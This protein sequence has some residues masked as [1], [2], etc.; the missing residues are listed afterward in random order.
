MSYTFNLEISGLFLI[1]SGLGCSFPLP[2]IPGHGVNQEA[3][4]EGSA[5]LHTCAS[6]SSL[7][8]SSLI[9]SR[10]SGS[11]IPRNT[12]I[13]FLV[14]WLKGMRCHNFYICRMLVMAPGR[15][16]S[17][18]YLEPELLG[19]QSKVIGTGSQIFWWTARGGERHHSPSHLF[20]D[21]WVLP[22][23]EMVP[24]IECWFRANA[25]FWRILLQPSSLVSPCWHHNFVF[26]RIF[27][28]STKPG[29]WDA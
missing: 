27:Y 13:S 18:I 9:S 11:V 16:S 4:T 21:A 6:L 3:H 17:P 10:Q 8:R 29:R 22:V 28:F 14:C 1:L 25:A 20:L 24:C 5:V 2:L 23:G 26:E 7:W 15:N 19:Q 12:V